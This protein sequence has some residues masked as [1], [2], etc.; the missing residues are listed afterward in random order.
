[1]HCLLHEKDQTAAFVAFGPAL[2]LQGLVTT[3]LALS[4]L[5]QWTWQLRKLRRQFFLLTALA[6]GLTRL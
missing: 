4:S 1:M 6:S 3:S 5:V 2:G